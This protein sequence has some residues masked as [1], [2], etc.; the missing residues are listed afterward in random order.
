MK[1][2]RSR[3]MYLTSHSTWNQVSWCPVSCWFFPILQSCLR[4]WLPKGLTRR[5]MIYNTWRR[6][7]W[8][9]A[10]CGQ[11]CERLWMAA[12]CNEYPG[13]CLHTDLKTTAVAGQGWLGVQLKLSDKTDPSREGHCQPLT[14]R[15]F[16]G[17]CQSEFHLHSS[18][19]I[20]VELNLAHLLHLGHRSR[21]WGWLKCQLT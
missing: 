20:M 8:G 19:H 2:L 7:S 5:I 6:N 10:A 12:F 13:W 4:I 16:Q 9:L 15:T 21:T 1:K 11:G 18:P 3:V 17:R 14:L